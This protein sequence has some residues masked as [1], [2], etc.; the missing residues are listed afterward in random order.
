ME[1]D[2][3]RGRSDNFKLLKF[4]GWYLSDDGP[5]ERSSKLDHKIGLVS[6][7]LRI[8]KSDTQLKGIL[9]FDKRYLRVIRLIKL[10]LHFDEVFVKA[11]QFPGQPGHF[12]RVTWQQFQLQSVI[13]FVLLILRPKLV[14]HC[15]RLA[16]FILR[17]SLS[18]NKNVR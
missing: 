2:A 1:K 7:I 12:L 16:T 15:D 9:G 3:Q 6:K 14:P 11:E 10:Y 5:V 4:T 13:D 8:P 17:N 18:G